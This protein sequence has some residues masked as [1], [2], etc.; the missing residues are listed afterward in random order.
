MIVFQ[1]RFSVFNTLKHE[2]LIVI[3]VIGFG[4][5]FSSFSIF[6]IES[7]S[8]ITTTS[9]GLKGPVKVMIENRISYIPPSCRMITYSFFN[10]KGQM[11][12]ER[13]FYP[14]TELV[15]DSL[16]DYMYPMKINGEY[17]GLDT[18]LF[19]YHRKEI[20][21]Y[22]NTNKRV[23]H[24][25]FNS[26]GIIS[27]EELYVYN[28]HDSLIL[29]YYFSMDEK[30]VCKDTSITQYIYK[31]NGNLITLT[32]ISSNYD[33]TISEMTFEK[34]KLIRNEKHWNYKNQN[35]LNVEEERYNRKGKLV[36]IFYYRLDDEMKY[37]LCGHQFNTYTRNKL[38]TLTDSS[39]HELIKFKYNFCGKKLI[40]TGYSYGEERHQIAFFDKYGNL[41]NEKYMIKDES[42][43]SILQRR[44]SYKYDKYQNWISQKVESIYKDHSESEITNRS[45]VYY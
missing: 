37:K 43:S 27:F 36:D 24:K 13:Y 19:D 20:Y 32:T 15:K 26:K 18:T 7:H 40:K 1:K 35:F 5:V 28:E 39:K 14:K 3:L 44:T 11:F 8:A 34:G 6:K 42:E 41:I 9:L 38:K 45:F 17:T 29:Q 31:Y 12:A 4:Y 25:R 2:N 33:T 22:S 23:S 30:G 10:T 16:I 21:E